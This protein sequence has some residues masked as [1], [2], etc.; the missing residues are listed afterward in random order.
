MSIASV[1][2]VSTPSRTA[3]P[4]WAKGRR[5]LLACTVAAMIAAGTLAALAPASGMDED[6]ARLL[7]FM[8]LLKGTFAVVAFAGAWWRLA[9]PAPV[10][11]EIVYIAGPGLMAGGSVALWQ[12]G[13]VTF[14]TV[15]LHA[16]M[17]ALL[18]AALTD[19]DFIPPRRSRFGVRDLTQES[20]A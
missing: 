8:A 14:A 13:A 12:V 7:R 15:A 16:G 5:W 1:A 6:L 9:R 11:R 10:W 4:D 20:D 3:G 19:P 18:A 17:V 2:E